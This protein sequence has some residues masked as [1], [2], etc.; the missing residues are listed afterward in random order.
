M[1][2]LQQSKEN[3]FDKSLRNAFEKAISDDTPLIKKCLILFEEIEHR[4]NRE[5]NTTITRA[6]I[7]KI[8]RLIIEINKKQ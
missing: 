2:T 4:Y 3:P 6:Q 1:N 8:E 5:C 7:Q